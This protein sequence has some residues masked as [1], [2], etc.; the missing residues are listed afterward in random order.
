MWVKVIQWVQIGFGWIVVAG[1]LLLV[2]SVVIFF[3]FK[4]RNFFKKLF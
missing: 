1:L 2:E 4:V 3:F